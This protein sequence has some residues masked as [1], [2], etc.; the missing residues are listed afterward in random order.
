MK[1]AMMKIGQMASYLDTGL[2]E[3]VRQTLASLQADAPPMSPDL[4][5][6]QIERAFGRGP[7]ELF[8]EWDPT[9]IAAASIGQVHRAITREEQAVAVK[10]QYPGVADAVRAD[11]GNAGWLF[12]GI[13]MLFPAS[14]R[15]RSSTR[16]R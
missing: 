11:L 6:G 9:P 2:P 16:S 15:S 10:I 4:A 14:I 12:N 1:G 5:A 8:L 7:D 3:P 13:A